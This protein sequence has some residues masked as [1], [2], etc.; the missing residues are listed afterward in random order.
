MLCS[1]EETVPALEHVVD[2]N[3]AEPVTKMRLAEIKRK[4]A[5]PLNLDRERRLEELAW[6]FFSQIVKMDLTRK[7][8]YLLPH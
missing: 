1:V 5:P 7:E 6:Y 3:N 8:L 4:T 2:F